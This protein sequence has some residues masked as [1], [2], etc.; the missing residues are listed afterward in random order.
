LSTA[1]LYLLGLERSP[2]RKKECWCF[3]LLQRGKVGLRLHPT[4]TQVIIKSAFGYKSG[5]F[6]LQLF[7]SKFHDIS[8]SLYTVKIQRENFYME[9]LEFIR[10]MKTK[11]QLIFYYLLNFR[12]KKKRLKYRQCPL[13]NLFIE[14][15]RLKV[16][17]RNPFYLPSHPV[18]LFFFFFKNSRLQRLRISTIDATWWFKIWCGPYAHFWHEPNKTF[19][20]IV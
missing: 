12:Q 8:Q 6:S 9:I 11:T 17:W 20:S 13:F 7:N 10:V 2:E 5:N 14:L 16:Y 19:N 1:A 4:T 15:I 3:W 18:P